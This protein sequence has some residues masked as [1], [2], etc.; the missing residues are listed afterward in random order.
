M[1][2]PRGVV[3]PL[4]SEPVSFSRS[5][6]TLRGGHGSRLRVARFIFVIGRTVS[7][8]EPHEPED[9]DGLGVSGSTTAIIATLHT[10]CVVGIDFLDGVRVP[11][12]TLMLTRRVTSR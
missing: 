5:D 8:K 1:R 3:V 7:H 12:D 6:Q 9:R 4:S 10:R 2:N 11:S